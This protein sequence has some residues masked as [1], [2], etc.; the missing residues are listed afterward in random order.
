MFFTLI[1]I[2]VVLVAVI[3]YL[4]YASGLTKVK[5]ERKPKNISHKQ[6]EPAVDEYQGYIPPDE[7]VARSENKPHTSM[8]DR[9]NVTSGDIPLRIRLDHE[10]SGLRKR[11]DKLDINRDPNSYDYDIDE[12][13]EEEAQ[14][15]KLERDREFYKNE[16]LGGTKED[17]V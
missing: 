11:K 7:Q 5:I 17:Q 14:A 2:S 3:L 9:M 10:S 8:R 4:P 12:L 6:E 16:K 15:A 13:I 1:I